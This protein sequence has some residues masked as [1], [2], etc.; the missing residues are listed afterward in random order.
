LSRRSRLLFF[1][2]LKSFSIVG[3]NF[4]FLDFRLS[5]GSSDIG[6][7]KTPTEAVEVFDK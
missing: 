2:A 7:S 5:V 6:L 4:L 1:S 3:S